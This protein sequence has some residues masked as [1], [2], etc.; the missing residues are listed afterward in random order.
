MSARDREARV[1]AASEHRSV[2]LALS[3]IAGCVVAVAGYALLRIVQA[4][5]LTEPDPALVFWSVHA[6][7]FW[8]AW[9]VAYAGGMGAFCTWIATARAPERTARIL[10]TAIVVAT[11]LLVVQS[12]FVP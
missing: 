4:L 6:G 1:N 11:V 8:R 9:T 2:R 3:M 10:T 12:A 5:V 7:Y